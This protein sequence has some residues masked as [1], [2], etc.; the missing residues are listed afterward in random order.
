M[1][2]ER[3]RSGRRTQGAPAA[4]LLARVLRGVLETMRRTCEAARA[5]GRLI[6]RT[7]SL[8]ASPS[9]SI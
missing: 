4:A 2:R 1:A 6:C 3:G 7:P 5:S 9:G 8:R